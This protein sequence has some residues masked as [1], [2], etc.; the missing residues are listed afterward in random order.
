[1]IK[2]VLCSNNLAIINEWSATIVFCTTTNENI[3]KLLVMTLG[4][5][6][7]NDHENTQCT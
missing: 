1:M 4:Y 7:T 5:Q 6:K 3:N 2:Y